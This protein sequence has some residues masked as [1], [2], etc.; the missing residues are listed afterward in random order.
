MGAFDPFQPDTNVAYRPIWAELSGV[1]CSASN[2]GPG[3]DIAAPGSHV[4]LPKPTD[5]SHVNPTDFYMDSFKGTSASA[6]FVAGAAALLYAIDPS[7]PTNASSV[8]LHLKSTLLNTAD[9]LLPAFQIGNRLN[10]CRAVK[11]SL[12][13]AFRITSSTPSDQQQNVQLTTSEI[14]VS[15]SLP[16]GDTGSLPPAL[17]VIA[18]G[19]Q[20]QGSLSVTTD[21]KNIRFSPSLPLTAASTYTLDLSE[22]TDL[23]GDALAGTTSISFTTAAVILPPPDA[24]IMKSANV[25]SVT[26]GGALTYTITA[27][28]ATGTADALNVA[29]TDPLPSGVSF[30]SCTVSEGGCS[31]LNG[32]VT[33]LFGTLAGGVSA[34]LTINATAPTVTT[35]TTVT[36][37]ATVSS[38]N[39]PASNTGNNQATQT[40]TVNPIV[41][42]TKV[43]ALVISPTNTNILYAGT[44]SSGTV[45]KTIDGG[46]HWFPLA[47][48]PNA[49]LSLAIHPTNPDVVY[50]ATGSGLF[51]TLDGGQSWSALTSGL[52]RLPEV[53][54]IDPVSPSSVYVGT[55]SGGIFKSTD[56]GQNWM[57]AN[58]GLSIAFVKTIAI[59]PNAPAILY[60]GGTGI[61]ESI[62]AAQMWT[63][64]NLPSVS[65]IS[66][67][68]V[69]PRTSLHILA[70]SFG[71]IL[72]ST[73]GGVSWSASATPISQA[74]DFA[75]STITSTIFA[76]SPGLG[77]FKSTSGGFLWSPI[78]SG[79]TTLQAQTVS[80]LAIDPT[81]NSLLYAGTD[82]G[83]FKSVDGGQTWQATGN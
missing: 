41:R 47:T 38:D 8:P 45:Y 19:M 30:T 54:R 75:F 83:I 55:D 17:H 53:I 14:D 33:A 52:T 49:S 35:S 37:I 26:S 79:L 5:L 71:G 44:N 72:F 27:Q 73:D 58:S 40:L 80:A 42:P 48:L 43:I 51:K 76:A 81:N 67:I 66:A 57:Q 63:M 36:N 15:F 10:V 61:F 31:A 4:F 13:A 62:D 64:L 82:A 20:V 6:P 18:N 78:N 25:S 56:E 70:G 28:N 65:S 32:T 1:V 7:L 3:V 22:I 59:D 50:A 46:A 2:F 16:L 29:V 77:V 24:T 9:V 11:T 21:G 69:D 23:C 68:D 60:A 12:N 34:S 74:R 39:E